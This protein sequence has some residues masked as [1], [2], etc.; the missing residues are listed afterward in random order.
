MKPV[1]AAYIAL[2]AASIG[3]VAS[4]TLETRGSHLVHEK[5]GLV[6][7]PW[8]K[9]ARVHRDAILPVRIGLAQSNLDD[10]YEHLMDL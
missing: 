9:G 1:P 2:L 8:R 4:T 10:A 3:A 6:N 7:T 5:R